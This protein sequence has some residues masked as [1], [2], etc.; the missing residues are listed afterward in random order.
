MKLQSLSKALF[1]RKMQSLGILN[2]LQNKNKNFSDPVDA[3]FARLIRLVL[4]AG[5]SY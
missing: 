5:C 1:V 4:N 3:Q 2:V